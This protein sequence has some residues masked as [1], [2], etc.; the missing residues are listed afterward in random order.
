MNKLK[1]EN[2]SEWRD[3]FIKFVIDAQ[4][5]GIYNF[6]WICGRSEMSWQCKEGTC[7]CTGADDHCHDDELGVCIPLELH[8]PELGIHCHE[9]HGD[10][11]CFDPEG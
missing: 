4:E 10:C 8:Y 2:Y 9:C 11:R 5:F 7:K 1:K 6:C 3:K